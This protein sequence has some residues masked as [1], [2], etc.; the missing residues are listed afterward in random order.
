MNEEEY[1]DPTRESEDQVRS[2]DELIKSLQGEVAELRRDLERASAA[3][4]ASRKEVSVCGTALEDLKESERLRAAA[5]EKVQ[6]LSEELGDLR[7]RNAD[8]QLRLRN[9]YIA[10]IANLRSELDEQRR[11]DV[12]A[13]ESEGKIGALREEFRK[14][15]ATLEESHKAE[16]E[17]L[18]RS[19]EQWQEKLR[20]G[21]RDLQ[22]RH[23]T[24][25]EELQTKH[26]EEI[27]ALK[28][29]HRAQVEALKEERDNSVQPPR[30]EGVEQK[31][32]LERNVR[33]GTGREYEEERHAERERPSA[34]LQALRSAAASRELELQKELRSAVEDRHSEVEELRLELEQS[35]AEAEE[36]RKNDLREIKRLAE[37][38]E[39]ELK[40]E[41]AARLTEEKKESE[42]RIESLEVQREADIKALR[43]QHA[44][45]LAEAR[46][47]LEER[48][49]AEEERHR[50]EIS[51]LK[52]RL[53]GM[54]T[55]QE[56]EARLY[57][58]RLEEL[59]RGRVT[60]RG[61]AE[62]E[63]ERQLAEGKEERTHLEDRIAELQNALEESGAL[64]A[65]LREALEVASSIGEETGQQDDEEAK[66][67]TG[68][69]A[70]MAVAQEELE[71]RF[72]EADAARHLAEERV[73][74]LETRLSEA[75]EVNKR[76]AQELEK[77][78]EGLR[79]V[80]DP[81]QRLRA[82]IS[83]FNASDH[84][85]TVA[86]ISKSLGLPKV[87]VSPDGGSSSQIKKPVVTFVWSDMAWR[88]YVSDPT[89]GVEEPRVYL[90]GAG[91]DPS[92]V[93]R[94]D[95]EPNARMDAQGHLILGVQAW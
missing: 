57:G 77:A 6:T 27:E 52:E 44:G 51:A 28:E 78:L 87:H 54:R 81:E 17:E 34:E 31:V 75:E 41:Q 56:A 8:E 43:E 48:L 70:E 10:D 47:E 45:E 29:E 95:L 33:E 64:E 89:E 83:L 9:K 19:A 42:R 84:T 11:A 22:E 50:S 2:A 72:E 46:R 73:S 92:E 30:T 14:E 25:I 79:R 74:D 32:E 18:K 86:S 76:H 38:R 3:L 93:H 71:R 20:D 62:E 91:D 67:A 23:K 35:A 12:A 15:R 49:T 4:R 7:Q 94:P 26:A 39:R 5:E 13:A 82:G 80:S 37:A 85:R 69:V 90:V 65:E 59:E 1:R 24:E 66:S 55:R 88:R 63:L 60:E 68:S 61:A 21:Y 58:E 36:R 40:R 16:V 53:E